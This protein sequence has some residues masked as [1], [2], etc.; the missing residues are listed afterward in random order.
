[1]QPLSA[2]GRKRGA[3]WSPVGGLEK[4]VS[5]VRAGEC[6]AG[7]FWIRD[8]RR[9]GVG[10]GLPQLS[11][12][13]E[14]APELRRQRLVCGGKVGRRRGRRR[15]RKCVCLCVRETENESEH[16]RTRG[17]AGQKD[18]KKTYPRS[19]PTQISESE[20]RPPGSYLCSTTYPK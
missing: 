16:G 4:L 3:T 18:S 2:L 17:C 12:T 6:L 1:M 15:K 7:P 9:E 13:Q 8:E 10:V 11:M 19:G 20:I 5:W 14:S